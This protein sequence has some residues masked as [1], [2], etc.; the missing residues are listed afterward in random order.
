MAQTFRQELETSLD[1]IAAMSAEIRK[2]D[3]LKW[4]Y[5]STGVPNYHQLKDD[6]G[7]VAIR[8]IDGMV[9]LVLANLELVLSSAAHDKDPV[10]AFER[11]SDHLQDIT[12]NDGYFTTGSLSDGVLDAATDVGL[13]TA[14]EAKILRAERPWHGQFAPAEVADHVTE[15][16]NTIRIICRRI[17]AECASTGA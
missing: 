8:D 6:P 5:F 1:K 13:V 17:D 16:E 2:V 11:F 12:K 7:Y 4:S 15:L 10:K 14:N 9:S 3:F